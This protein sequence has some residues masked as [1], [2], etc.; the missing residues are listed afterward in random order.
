MALRKRDLT[1]S[2]WTLATALLL[3]LLLLSLLVLGACDG[4]EQSTTTALA[5]STASTEPI[6]VACLSGPLLVA[7]DVDPAAGSR[8]R[9]P[10]YWVSAKT[11][12]Q[13]REERTSGT[14]RTPR[15]MSCN[16]STS[17]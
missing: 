12:G 4:N 11:V 15:E 6:L 13:N 8:L 16:L 1:P 14:S 7:D 5:D 17:R 9:R 10:Y 3:L 2:P